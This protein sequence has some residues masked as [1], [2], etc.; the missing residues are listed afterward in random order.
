MGLLICCFLFSCGSNKGD[1]IPINTM[2]VLILE[3]Q[4]A[5]EFYANYIYKDST[6]N[7]DSARSVAFKQVLRL[8]KVDSTR[9]YKSF[10]YYRSEPERFKILLDSANAYANR[11][12]EERY[13]L[14]STPA[15]SKDSAQ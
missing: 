12:R 8:H 15:L 3:N 13:K 2:K 10:A 11:L 14:E 7:R 1:I 5:E 9:F 4:M 6:I